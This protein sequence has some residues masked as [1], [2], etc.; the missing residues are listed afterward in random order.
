MLTSAPVLAPFRAGLQKLAVC[1]PS[2][3]CHSADSLALRASL[4]RPMSCSAWLLMRGT[5]SNRIDAYRYHHPRP[6]PIG[7][8]ARA[9]ARRRAPARGPLQQPGAHSALDR[10]DRHPPPR[11]VRRRGGL[12]VRAT[13]N[14]SERASSGRPDARRR[15]Q[16]AI[17]RR[18]AAAEPS[19][20]GRR[21][22]SGSARAGAT[23]RCPCRRPYFVAPGRALLAL[24]WAVGN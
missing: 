3:R 4:V 7:S 24:V 12:G 22:T 1:G 2:R 11:Q 21:G 23:P 20:N 6:D 10:R 19:R 17:T 16:G 9:Q 8:P 18:A 5:Q 15:R 13:A 14:A